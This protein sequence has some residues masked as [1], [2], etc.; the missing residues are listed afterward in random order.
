MPGTDPGQRILLRCVVY[1]LLFT[2]VCLAVQ[3]LVGAYRSDHSQTGD[4]AAYFVS[5][6]MIADYFVHHLPSNPL[7]FANE[8]YQHFPRVGLGH[9]PPMFD[10]VQAILFLVFGSRGT[11]AV[12]FQAVIG[13]FCAGLPAAIVSRLGIILGLATGIAVLSVPTVLFLIG[14]VMVDNFL[15]VLVT[16]TALGWARFY[17]TRTWLG[18]LLFALPAAAAI[19]TKGTA[20][21]LALL[22]IIHLSLKKDLRFLCN[23]RTIFSAIV[24]G[25]LTIPWYVATYRLAAAG[26]VYSWGWHYTRMAAPFFLRGLVDSLGIPIAACYVAGLCFAVAGS[27]GDE[28]FD[29]AAFVAASLSML[30]MPMITPVDLAERY[31]IPA[32]PSAAIVATWGLCKSLDRVLPAAAGYPASRR[33]TGSA[34]GAAVFLLSAASVFQ[35]PHL[36]PYH[37]G[38]IAAYILAANKP[39]PLVLVSGSADVEGALIASFAERD[40]SWSH[41]V[42]R[43]SAVLARSNFIGGD[44]AERF[45][46]PGAM[47][48]WIKDNEIGWIVVQAPKNAFPHNRTLR[49]AL[50]SNLLDARLVASVPNRRNGGSNLLLYALPAADK[51]PAPADTVFSLLRPSRRF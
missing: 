36:E 25:L 3:L 2:G 7:T 8:Y 29:I 15:A 18:A 30:I 40:R 4:E 20:F 39:N 34:L 41:Y 22:P 12:A 47:A 10:A 13:G 42:V 46:S 26:F 37:S 50:A 49:V 21:G 31:L 14:T 9:Y 44:Y 19:L 6:L 11:V 23:R 33:L 24:V 45:K 38:R 35:K 48:Q 28:P 43:G 1:I 17:R 5:S 32:L 27:K 16:L 51:K